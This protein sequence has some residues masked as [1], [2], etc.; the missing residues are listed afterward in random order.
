[1]LTLKVRPSQRLTVNGS[2]CVENA[3]DLQ[4]GDQ[5]GQQNQV[6]RRLG[7]DQ[8]EIR[9][10][11][12]AG[13]IQKD[14]QD[15]VRQPEQRAGDQEVAHEKRMIDL[16]E[17]RDADCGRAL[18]PLEADQI[19]H[20]GRTRPSRHL[21]ADAECALSCA[22]LQHERFAVVDAGGMPYAAKG[23]SPTTLGQLPTPEPEGTGLRSAKPA[24]S[25]VIAA[26]SALA[27]NFTSM[28]YSG[29]SGSHAG[30]LCGETNMPQGS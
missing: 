10:L 25:A 18:E 5:R 17:R 22:R 12:Q 8:P 29:R 27:N 16:R 4:R 30:L 19:E 21:Q 1:M 15:P 11:P 3:P 28:V 14:I 20:E 9:Q 23:R 2:P 6:E 24:L 13:S 26:A 7:Q